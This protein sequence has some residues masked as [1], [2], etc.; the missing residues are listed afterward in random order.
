[1]AAVAALVGVSCTGDVTTTLPSSTG[2]TP[3]I[4]P[5]RPA[6]G[7]IVIGAEQ[8]PACLN[9]ITACSSATWYW[10]TVGE[11]VLPYAMVLDLQ[12]NFEA[13]PLLTEAPTLDNG[14]ITQNPFTLTYKLNPVANWSDSTPI[15][16]KDFAF[17]WKAIMHTL[18]AYS[19]AGY[20]R[21]S[22]IDTSDPKT[23]VIAFNSVFVDW[24]D[25]FGGVSQGLLEAHAFPKFEND[26]KP[27]LKDEMLHSL[28][29][30][31][32]P[33]VMK[34][35]TKDLAV[36][37][38]KLLMMIDRMLLKSCAIPP[39]RL[40]IASIFCACT[41]C[42]SVRWRSV[43]SWLVPTRRWTVPVHPP[44]PDLP[45]AADAARRPAG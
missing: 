12:G 38:R 14:L 27:N 20:D 18:G 15:T 40:P 41:S 44:P 9:P 29:F 36:L 37:T 17:T 32:G 3:A 30:S 42:C 39:V 28:P 8:W 7:S 21:I 4:S 5:P 45:C 35:W 11:Q 34:S 13:S 31:G 22:S 2:G 6:S 26:P 10:Y 25:L 33:W 23:A 16:S 19:T 1:M 43:M 24:A